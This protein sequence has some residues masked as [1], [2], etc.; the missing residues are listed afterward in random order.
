[1]NQLWR[2]AAAAPRDAACAGL[3]RSVG[4]ERLPCGGGGSTAW[5]EPP[6]CQSTVNSIATDQTDRP[7][8][9]G[10]GSSSGSRCWFQAGRTDGRAPGPH[11]RS[12]SDN[13]TGAT[14][15]TG[16]HNNA[17]P[18][19]RPDERTGRRAGVRAGEGRR[20]S[21]AIYRGLLAAQRYRTVL[22][23]NYQQAAQSTYYQPPYRAS[24]ITYLF[25]YHVHIYWRLSMR[26]QTAVAA[27]TTCAS[28]FIN[29]RSNDDGCNV[30]SCPRVIDL[31]T[32]PVL[33]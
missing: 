20:L 4:S 2:R 5:P 31:S 33:A 29:K 32:R 13:V 25:I 27:V 11:G 17:G 10:G 26:R 24:Y 1:M 21:T 6:Q 23:I 12:V 9:G 19:P 16:S 28:F 7:R 30:A 22:I 14:G 3:Q 18:E 15:V 8:R